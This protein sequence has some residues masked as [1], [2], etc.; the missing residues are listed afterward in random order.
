[1][2]DIVHIRWVD[3][4]STQDWREKGDLKEMI[5]S[6]LLHVDSVGMLVFTS[7]REA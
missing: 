1:M 2:I 5:A 6:D 7:Y 3:A 4:S